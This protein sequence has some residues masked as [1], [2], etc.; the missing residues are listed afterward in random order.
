MLSAH[1]PPFAEESFPKRGP[2]TGG[3]DTKY[4]WSCLWRTKELESGASPFLFDSIFFF[5]FFGP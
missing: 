4:L 1:R 2:R 3:R 5:F